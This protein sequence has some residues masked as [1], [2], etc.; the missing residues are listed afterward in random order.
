M[1]SEGKLGA[2]T[3]G[4]FTGGGAF[5]LLDDD[6][7]KFSSSESI[8]SALGMEKEK[9]YNFMDHVSLR[10]ILFLRL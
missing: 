3:G 6:N 7:M 1:F 4:P 10:V 2:F 8:L 5:G 9:F